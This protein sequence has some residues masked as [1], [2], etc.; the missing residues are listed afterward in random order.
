MT[1]RAWIFVGLLLLASAVFFL[2]SGVRGFLEGQEFRQVVVEFAGGSVQGSAEM[3]PLRWSGANV[4]SGSLRLSGGEGS[5]IRS[6]QAENLQAQIDWAAVLSGA[7]RLEKFLAKSLRAEFGEAQG[8]PSKTTPSPSVGWAFLP[9]RF[10]LGVVLISRADLDFGDTEIAETSL[11]VRPAGQGWQFHGRGGQFLTPWLPH[12]GIEAFEAEWSKDQLTV[13]SSSLGLGA[14]GKISASGKWPGAMEVQWKE[15]S[16]ADLGAGKWSEKLDGYLAGAAR[17]E[18]GRVKGQAEWTGGTLRG[19][20]ILDQIAAFTGRNEFRALS[21]QKATAD[22]EIQ[23]GN[24]VFQNLVFK[25]L[26]L[27]QV[28][29]RISV[30]KNHELRGELE[31][32]VTPSLLRSLPGART[33]VFTREADG[34]VWTSVQVGG[35]MDAP[36][37]NLSERLVSAVG[38]A[39]LE[40]VKPVLQSMPEP[41]RKA[42]DETMNTLF[43]ILGR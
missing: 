10:E 31:V 13:A 8:S 16:P 40:A 3:A 20:E 39:A 34:L 28:K 24:F 27:M 38:D 29:G 41:A 18:A 6:I 26:D 5:K 32:G 7:W 12:L 36:T 2:A 33:M 21:I 43:D 22:F 35:T 30:S 1:N 11:E 15:V 25:A 4:H 23:N 14:A 37:E 42:V 9:S 19:I 17:V